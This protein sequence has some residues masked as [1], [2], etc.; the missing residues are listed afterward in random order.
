MTM[1]VKEERQDPA[2]GISGGY[3]YPPPVSLQ[4]GSSNPP[5]HPSQLP[6]HTQNVHPMYQN[7]GMSPYMNGSQQQP[8]FPPPSQQQSEPEKPKE[9]EPEKPNVSENQIDFSSFKGIFGWTT[10]DGINV[11]YI[12]R[13]EKRFV[14]VRVVEQKLLSRYPNSYPDELGKH[15]PLTSYFI[16]GHEAKLLNEINLV[17][18]GGEFGQKQFNTKDLIVL[19]EDFE[20]FYNLVKK[21]F[22]LE[23]KGVHRNPASLSTTVHLNNTEDDTGDPCGWI[24]V[25]NTVTPYV[26]RKEQGKFVPL[27]VM[28][29]AAALVI[30]EKGVL[31]TD[32]EC[33]LLNKACKLAGFNFTF[34][35]TTRIICLSDITKHCNV[36]LIELPMENPLQHAQYLDL[37]SEQSNP[38]KD[39][40]MSPKISPTTGDVK[41]N[42]QTSE[43]MNDNQAPLSSPTR[44]PPPGPMNQPYFDPRYM[45]MFSYNRYPMYPVQHYGPPNV[46]VNQPHPAFPQM[47]MNRPPYMS[48]GNMTGPPRNQTPDQ[49]KN[50]TSPARSNAGTNNTARSP[51]PS[52]VTPPHTGQ[53]QMMQQPMFPNQNHYPRGMQ[54]GSMPPTHYS[55]QMPPGATQ[56]QPYGQAQRA[57]N[58]GKTAAQQQSRFP[59]MPNYP[60][61]NMGQQ[62]AHMMHPPR[63]PPAPNTSQSEMMPPPPHMSGPHQGM[64]RQQMSNAQQ[65]NQQRQQTPHVAVVAP[66]H[67][68][69]IRANH[70][71]QNGVPPPRT[72]PKV[73]LSSGGKPPEEPKTNEPKSPIPGLVDKIKGVW[74]AGKSI[75]CMHL[76][77]PQRK[78]K[79]CLVEAVCKLYFNGCSVNEF[80]Y[81]LENVLGVP[82]MTCTDDEEKSFIHYYSLPVTVLKCNKMIDFDDLE[83]FFPQL[84]Y[85]FRDKT[86]ANG[87][88][89]KAPTTNDSS[90]ANSV[91]VSEKENIE[92]NRKRLSGPSSGPPVKK[93]NNRLDEITK[94]L[95]T[96]HESSMS[97]GYI[98]LYF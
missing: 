82:L 24:Q 33:D 64:I 21:T 53:S 58:P 55:G 22:P 54:R 5:S 41:S 31:P 30:P 37:S 77:R 94:R 50:R 4:N 27:S 7:N 89:S 49:M 51:A 20:D 46:T 69:G 10:I 62:Q 19:L 52:R 1:Q 83:K 23:D 34:S 67:Q 73:P 72:D 6:P 60:I 87:E 66:Q 74:L 36:H 63:G 47:P 80:L 59:F 90:N 56:R 81:A 25:N 35:K 78:G 96:Q 98:E 18:C 43:Q 17:H 13:K 79:F 29:Y 88:P 61:P 85:M 45:T 76:D 14:S 16:T 97:E 95:M 84:S 39:P 9:A 2:Y 48:N 12:F 93:K 57:Q 26:K 92:V 40:P 68:Q 8:F 91:S 70:P 75:S 15:Q 28:K 86:G 65:Y 44:F 11:P 3:Q 38:V 42:T 71:S 32:E